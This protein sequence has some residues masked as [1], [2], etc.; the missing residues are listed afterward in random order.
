M[1]NPDQLVPALIVFG[2]VIDPEY[3]FL[4]RVARP[5]WC[6]IDVGA[7]IG[8][9]TVYALGTC[10]QGR[11]HA[12]EPGP[13]NV[14]TLQENLRDNGLA[15]RAVVLQ[16]AC[17]DKAG[18]GVLA[19]GADAYRGTVTAPGV[20]GDVQVLRLDDYVR[21]HEL[22]VDVLK[23]NVAG[24]EVPVLLGT[25]GLLQGREIPLIFVLLSP[26]LVDFL[27]TVLGWGYQPFFYHPR[28]HA[29][30]AAGEG[31]TIL[32]HQ[33]WPARALILVSDDYVG[34]LRARGV[35]IRG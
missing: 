11:V 17:G 21:D 9:F 14:A 19:E 10:P 2:E 13:D 30:I 26:G 22:A 23:L 15:E 1:R 18:K 28:D 25:S 3:A 6:F 12:F 35:E 20:G 34:E 31:K 27:P 29:L 4:A 33:P 7:A 5:N 16:Q 24:N 8:Q 32:N